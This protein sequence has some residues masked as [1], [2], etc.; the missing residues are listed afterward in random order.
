MSDGTPTAPLKVVDSKKRRVTPVADGKLT[1]PPPFSPKNKE[2]PTLKSKPSHDHRRT[3]WAPGRPALK[4]ASLERKDLL[5]AER[6]AALESAQAI[7][8]SCINTRAARQTRVRRHDNTIN[9][10]STP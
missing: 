6:N 4:K 7:P 10:L 5:R 9:P 3:C 1:P 2:A 8:N